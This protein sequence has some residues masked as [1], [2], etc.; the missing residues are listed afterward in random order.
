MIEWS[1]VAIAVTFAILVI[2]AIVVLLTVN[3]TVKQARISLL[4]LQKE[5]D[6]LRKELTAFLQDF[7]KTAN[8]LE[9]QLSA[10][11]P[12]CSSI[13]EA[14]ETVQYVTS[15]IT[16]VTNAL[17]ESAVTHVNRAHA[18]NTD[19]IGDVFDLVDIGLGL[20][21]KWQIVRHPV[22]PRST[23]PNES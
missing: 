14:G 7:K 12:F 6:A 19:R 20:W 15:S 5:T 3:T 1:V 11:E 4:Q 16:S 22:D 10:I 23:K 8:I 18:N 9:R 21:E 17:T 13:R 2:V